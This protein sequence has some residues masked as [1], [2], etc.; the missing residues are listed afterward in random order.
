LKE[1]VIPSPRTLAKKSSH[2]EVPSS[3][4]TATEQAENNEIK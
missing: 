2:V 1:T 4:P 3:K